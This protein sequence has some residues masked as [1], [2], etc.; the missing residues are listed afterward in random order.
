MR[1][2]WAGSEQVVIEGRGDRAHHDRAPQPDL[3]VAQVEVVLDVAV[4]QGGRGGQRRVVPERLDL[5]LDDADAAVEDHLLGRGQA[6][7]ARLRH[8]RAR[9]D[10]AVDRALEGGDQAYGNADL[11]ARP[12]LVDVDVDELL[13]RRAIDGVD[14]P[15]IDDHDV[16]G[17]GVGHRRHVEG[18]VQRLRLGAVAEEQEHG[19]ACEAPSNGL[20]LDRH[21]FLSSVARATAHLMGSVER[22]VR[23]GLDGHAGRDPSDE[24][25]EPPEAAEVP[26]PLGRDSC[27]SIRPCRRTT[28]RRR[29]EGRAR[30]SRVPSRAASAEALAPQKRRARRSAGISEAHEPQNPSRRVT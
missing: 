8:R 28:P 16:Q 5:G 24:S 22:L 25:P 1:D 7:V 15:V 2:D 10:E 17:A 14:V 29:V 9:D 3:G 6:R 11:H 4:P 12:P 18:L 13:T 21:L 23:S 30:A 26:D 27:V 20:V 19:R